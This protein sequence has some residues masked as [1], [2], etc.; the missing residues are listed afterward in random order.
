MSNINP[1][2][3]KAYD[4]RGVY[5]EEINEDAVYK[6]SLA[7][8]DFLNKR[9]GL[10]SRQI[11]VGRDARSSSDDLFEAVASALTSQSFDIID[12]GQ[13]STPLFYWAL[14]SERAAG[15][16]MI[17]ASHNPA[18]YNGLKIYGEGAFPFGETSGMNE[19][20][21]LTLKEK[22]V[23][24]SQAPGQ[25]IKK[26][27]LTE[28]LRFIKGKIDFNKIKPLKIVVD[29]GNGMIG[30]ELEEL[31]KNLSCQAEILF[32]EPDGAFPNH[33][34]NPI[35][36]ENLVDLK[37][38]VKER[39][40]DLGVAFDGDADRLVFVDEKGESV[41]GDFITA[42][43]GQ[44]LLKTVPGQR[45]FYEVRSSRSVPQ[46]I[47]AAGGIPVLGRPGHTLIKVQMRQEDILFGGEMSGHYFYREF[48]FIENSI[49]TMLEI[50]KILSCEQ[51]PLSELAA[52]LKK[53][54]SSGEI[55]FTVADADKTLADIEKNFSGAQIKKIDG[56]TVEFPDW[57]F[58]LRKSNTEP[59]VRL[60][61]EADTAALLEEKKR[62][63]T[64]L[65]K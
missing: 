22:P 15:G 64:A 20:K 46:A 33:E 37:R 59:L 2:I 16:I 56:I 61:M 12:I 34:A 47:A 23:A 42:L 7:F 53:Y 40:A 1:A 60:N 13:V 27:L 62:E 36:E 5:P 43:I 30:P 52:P 48:G 4:I 51:K 28:Y 24:I 9:G 44:E 17:T 18:Q 35:K 32:A 29:G 54:F 38:A 50:L 3:F 8:L 41:R 55:N 26:E 19:I 39:G 65:I 6:I 58:N 45:I 49:F 14:I 57:W 10:N 31:F 25:V 11:I 21:D 63:V